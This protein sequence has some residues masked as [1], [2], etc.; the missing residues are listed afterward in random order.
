MRRPFEPLLAS[1][2]FVPFGDLQALRAG[3]GSAVAEFDVDGSVQALSDSLEQL[4]T[5]EVQVEIIHRAV[6]AIN[7]SDVIL[8]GPAGAVII[9]FR[10]R[11]DVNARNLADR[12]GWD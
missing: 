7:E 12:E 3:L 11:P 9:G 4:S 6:G 2:Q 8:A 10:V 1:C 5:D